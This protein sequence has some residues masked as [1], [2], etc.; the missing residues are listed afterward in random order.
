MSNKARRIVAFKIITYSKTW[1]NKH[2]PHHFVLYYK[3]FRKIYR[4]NLSQL[5]ESLYKFLHDSFFSIINYLL[6]KMFLKNY[7]PFKKQTFS[8]LSVII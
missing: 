4:P 7:L 3:N 8:N 6:L 2:Q 5:R 1:E